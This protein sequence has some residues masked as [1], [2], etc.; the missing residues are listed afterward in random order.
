MDKKRSQSR[1]GGR[2]HVIRALDGG[3][4]V[5]GHNDLH[6]SMLLVRR[7]GIGRRFGSRALGEGSFL[8]EN[9]AILREGGFFVL[10]FRHV[11]RTMGSKTYSEHCPFGCFIGSSHFSVILHTRLQVECYSGW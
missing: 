6:F 5:F 11:W 10:R 8:H 1:I 9:C 7:S 4:G 3:Q 2:N